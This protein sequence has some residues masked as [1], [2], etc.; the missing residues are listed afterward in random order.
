MKFI[1]IIFKNY[2]LE[3]A[4]LPFVLTILTTLI[5]IV[6]T[7]VLVRKEIKKGMEK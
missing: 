3:Y 4:L 7:I 6:I 2:I 5:I 1:D